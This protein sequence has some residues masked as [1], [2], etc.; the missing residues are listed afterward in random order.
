VVNERGRGTE[1]GVEGALRCGAGGLSVAAAV[2]KLVCGSEKTLERG[3]GM[4]R[5]AVGVR[6]WMMVVGDG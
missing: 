3:P 1:K 2:T 6:A 5:V 4:K